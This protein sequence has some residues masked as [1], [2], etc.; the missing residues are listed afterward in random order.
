MELVLKGLLEEG[1]GPADQSIDLSWR[2]EMTSAQK[3]TPSDPA[4]R[5]CAADLGSYLPACIGESKLQ[6]QDFFQKSPS[7]GLVAVS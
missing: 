7:S 6:A 5:R 1:G 2:P 3:L 4:H